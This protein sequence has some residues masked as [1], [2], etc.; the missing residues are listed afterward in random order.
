VLIVNLFPLVC[1][2]TTISENR[3][4]KV[5]KLFS[6]I[7]VI[8]FIFTLAPATILSA[9]TKTLEVTKEDLLNATAF[10][11][12][13]AIGGAQVQ[14]VTSE[15]EDII[16]QAVVT[17]SSTDLEPTLT[18]NESNGVFTAD[19]SSG[20]DIIPS[21][22]TGFEEWTITIGTYTVDTDLVMSCGGVSATI[23]LGGLPLRNCMLTLGGVSMNV[24]FSTPTTR[25]VESITVTGGGMIFSMSHLGNT[26]FEKLEMLGGGGIVDLDFQGTYTSEQHSANIIVAGHLLGIS[27]PSDVGERAGILSVGI[28]L[29]VLGTGWESDLS[30]FFYQRYTTSDYTTQTKKIDI[31][32]TAVGS[33]GSIVRE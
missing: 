1:L 15:D 9:A 29:L 10:S 6:R 7:T 4:Y 5:K 12:S 13:F 32:V 17:Y 18:T 11:L 8:L 2:D 19:F 21:P 14:I 25:Q 16:V 26:D 23:D 27:L 24:D 3:R 30:L 33:F 31:E 20:D 28:P 22:I